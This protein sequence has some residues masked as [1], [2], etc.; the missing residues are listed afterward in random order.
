MGEH[1]PRLYISR[2]AMSL[3]RVVVTGIGLVTPCGT[4]TD[5]TWNALVAGRSGIGP[6]TRFDASRM[7]TRI[8]GEARDFEP[9]DFLDR[10]E[11]RRLD[12]YQQLAMA[13]ADLAIADAEYDPSRGDPFRAGVVVGS[14]VGGLQSVEDAVF[15]AR[16]AND[17]GLVSPMFILQLLPN[18][19]GSYISIRHGLKGPNWGT[20]SACSTGAHAIGEAL[21]LIQRGQADVLLAGGTEAPIGFMCISG[22]NALRAL[23]TRN[24]DPVR[25]SRPFDADRDG[26]VLAEGA[27]I[28]VLESLDHAERRGARIL[29][30]LAGY[31]A[32]A[33]AHHVTAPPPGHGSAQRCMRDAIAEAGLTPADVGYV[34]AHAT[35]TPVGDVAEADAIA[36]VFGD[37]A[38]KVAV[39]STKSMTGHMTGAA[40]AAESA[41]AI[42]AMARGV[43]PPTINLDRPDPA[44]TIDC[45]PNVARPAHLDAVMNNSFGFGGTNASLVFRRYSAG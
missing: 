27:A 45:V 44:I 16:T 43:I 36:A 29:A 31:A 12:R 10:K 8:A 32:T 24:D 23:S 38:S 11:I 6:I 21:R 3:P 13:A 15:T 28:L 2:S 4:G 22:F 41:F 39:S 14:C 40:G 42:L 25:A 18:I 37:A 26:F 1:A 9:L 7:A 35:A 19:A 33:D 34:N 30:E 5:A 20:N 17:P